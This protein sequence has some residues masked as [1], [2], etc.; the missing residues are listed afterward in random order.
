MAENDIE[1][2][3]RPVGKGKDEAERLPTETHVGEE[4]ATRQRQAKRQK[5][6]PGADANRRQ[7]DLA[8]EFDGAHRAERQARDGEIEAGVHQPQDDTHGDEQTPLCLFSRAKLSPGPP[9][10]REDDRRAGDTQ[11]R[12]PKHADMREEQHREGGSE[13][14]KDG[15]YDKIGV[16]RNAGRVGGY[17]MLV[18]CHVYSS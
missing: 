14:V 4:C 3:E 7:N 5:I 12:H 11:P 8:E 6:T 17:A 2:E 15:A 9:P 13:I 10:D 18:L 16:R 1:H